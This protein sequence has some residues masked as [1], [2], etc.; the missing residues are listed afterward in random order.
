MENSDLLDNEPAADE[1]S[2][3]PNAHPTLSSLT[4]VVANRLIAPGDGAS[5]NDQV[6]LHILHQLQSLSSAVS[7]APDATQNEVPSHSIEEAFRI[8]CDVICASELKHKS[9]AQLSN[10]RKV[11]RRAIRNLIK[12]CGNIPVAELN[13][14]HGRELFEWWSARVFPKDD[15]KP[16]HANTA[17]KDLVNLQSFYQRY[18]DYFGEEDRKNPF[19]KLRF[20]NV[21]YRN[22]PPFEHRWI[23]KKLLS[24]GAM[25]GL[26]EEARAIVYAMIETGCRPSE[27]FNL[28]AE[29][30]D[31]NHRVPH[32]K[33]RPE[34]K[35]ELKCQSAIRD[36]PLLGVSLQAMQRYPEGFPRYRDKGNTLSA[37]LNKAFRTNRLFPS[38]DHRIYSIRHSFENRM[39]EAG[40][41][42]G[43]RCKL[44]GHFESRPDYGTGGTLE[45]RA[46]ELSK[47]VFHDVKIS[48]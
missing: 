27:I 29:H 23:L 5:G 2:S 42:Y 26:N 10:W 37:T 32:L 17:N 1:N 47:I 16:L 7:S 30:I 38:P 33:L 8:Y 39:L 9:P 34:G 48:W 13:R 46:Q 41:D 19:R 35:R 4:D 20:R 15:S 12:V 43:V 18:W 31:L 40:I 14:A 3:E 36:V 28:Q 24:P 44:M 21:V 45:F 6:L 11:K 25:G 22:I